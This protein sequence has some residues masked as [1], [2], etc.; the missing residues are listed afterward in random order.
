MMVSAVKKE[1]EMPIRLI[2]SKVDDTFMK[3]CL[4]R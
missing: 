1:D 3:V 4:M 2:V